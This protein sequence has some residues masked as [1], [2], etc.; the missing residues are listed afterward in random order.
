MPRS[1]VWRLFVL[2]LAL[3]VAACQS[4]TSSTTTFKVDDIVESVVT[5]TH[6]T[7]AASTDG[8]SY[9]VVRGNNQPD[10]V[11]LFDWM[12]TFQITLKVNANATNKDV[13]LSFPITIASATGRVQ[14]ATGG[15]VTPPTGGEVEHYDSVLT[16]STGSQIS[17]VG[18]TVTMDFQVWYDLPSLRK[19]A[20]VTETII[21]QD[22]AGTQLTKTVSVVVDP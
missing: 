13:D 14:Q 15:I 21:L 1:R 11:L 6:A 12:T 10:D 4:P 8:K 9:R 16:S 19:E 22:A 2:L 18:G 3:P 5:P 7:A 17:A 20:L